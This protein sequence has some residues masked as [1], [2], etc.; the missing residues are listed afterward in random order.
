[1]FLEKIILID[2]DEKLVNAWKEAFGDEKN[3]EVLAGDYF[4]CPADA[5]VSPANSFG[6]MDGGLDLAIRDI[7]GYDTEERLKNKILLEY[8]GELPVGSAIIVNTSHEKW[9]YLISAPTMRVPMDV[10][11]TLNAYLAFRAILLAIK[12]FN[13][14]KSAMK[15]KS[16]VCSGLGTGIG[17]M[18]PRKC[19]AQMRVA[20]SYLTKPARIPS[21]QEI[22]EVH[23]RLNVVI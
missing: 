4:S 8:H 1:M 7:I 9:P 11:N 6:I 15:I 2:K 13:E 3:F 12:K 18:E 22:H 19:A 20:Y 21:F 10:S 14:N 23:R 16:V 17:C 5:M